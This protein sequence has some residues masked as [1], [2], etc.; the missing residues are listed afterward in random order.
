L[1]GGRQVEEGLEIASRMEAAGVDALEVD[2]GCYETWYWAHPTSYQPPGLMVDMAEATK[3]VVKIPVIA[4]GKLGYP[5]LAEELLNEGKADFICLGRAL[6]ADP[7]W[8][9]KV[10]E[11]RPEDIRPCIG[12]N[13]GCLG[14]LLGAKYTSCS[15]NPANGMERELALKPAEIRKSVLVVGGGPG[16]W[17]PQEWPP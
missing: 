13:D 10:E 1:P 5:E 12:D 15:V 16:V 2:A 6:F 3:K 8:P 9:N 11:G 17:R 14:R 4:I 7:E